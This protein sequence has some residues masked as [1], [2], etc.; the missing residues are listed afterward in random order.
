MFKV[1][2][3][4]PNHTFDRTPESMVALRGGFCGGAGQGERWA[5]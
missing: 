3:V 2:T 1:E 5:S 4:K